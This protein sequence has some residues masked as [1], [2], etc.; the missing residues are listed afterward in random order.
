MEMAGIVKITVEKGR[1]FRPG[2]TEE[3]IRKVYSIEAE[4][5]ESYTRESIEEIR[6]DLEKIVDTWLSEAPPPKSIVDPAK[7]NALPWKPY[8]EGHRAAWIFADT[9]G[10]EQLAEMI[11]HSEEGK[12]EIAEFTYRFSG[13]KE[14]PTM[15]ISRNPTETKEASS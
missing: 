4:V 9:K 11:R 5:P 12:V 1:T 13:P 6:L 3:W 2:N 7:L 14:N 8:K 10:A 15:F